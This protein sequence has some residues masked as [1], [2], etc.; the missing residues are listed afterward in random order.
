MKGITISL[1]LATL[2]MAEL[3]A[4]TITTAPASVVSRL[5]LSV[6]LAFWPMRHSN[7]HWS[8]TS[9]TG[10]TTLSVS[11]KRSQSIKPAEGSLFYVCS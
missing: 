4:V 9:P 5:G 10:I 8:R 7:R 11:T 1:M 2:A 3:P 6:D